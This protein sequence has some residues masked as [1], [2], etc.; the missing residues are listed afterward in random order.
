MCENRYDRRKETDGAW[1]IFDIFMGMP[2]RV[3]DVEQVGL[4]IEQADV[5]VD[6]LNEFY[7]MRRAASV[8]GGIATRAAKASQG[9]ARKAMPQPAQRQ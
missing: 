9:S 5:L 2:A 4:E 1:T 6:F 8:H 7:T 3:N